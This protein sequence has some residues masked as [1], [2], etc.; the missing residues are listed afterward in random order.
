VAADLLWTMTSLRTSEGLVWQRGWSATQYEKN[1]GA[2]L[3]TVLMES[4]IAQSFIL[5]PEPDPSPALL[6]L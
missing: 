3:Q 1:V 5:N 6:S 4:A 2:A